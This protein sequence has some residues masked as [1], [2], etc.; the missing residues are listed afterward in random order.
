MSTQSNDH[1]ITVKPLE[2]RGQRHIG[3]FFEYNSA[4][5]EQIKS[6]PQRKYSV[7]HRCWYIPYDKLSWHLFLQL[8]LPIDIVDAHGTRQTEATSDNAIIYPDESI[9][10]DSPL[11][12][13]EKVSGNHTSDI[14]SSNEDLTSIICQGGQFLITIKYNRDEIN[15]L[16]KLTASYWHAG[17]SKWVCKST[18]GNHKKLQERYKYWSKLQ[19]TQLEKVLKV[20][21]KS[22][23]ARIDVYDSDKS[24]YSIRIKNADKA[25]SLIK[26]KS[27]R[28]YKTDDG[29]WIISSA[30]CDIDKLIK[31]L[32]DMNVHVQDYRLL[33]KHADVAYSRDWSVRSKY[34][35]DKVPIQQKEVLTVYVHQ[36]IQERKSWNTIKQYFGSFLK[37]VLHHDPRSV[38]DLGQDDI[39]AYIS[40]IA[41]GV[42]SH[43][44]INR[45]QSA[46]RFY[47]NR[48]SDL[49]I[50]FDKIPRPKVAKSLPKILSKGEV[51]LM[52][53]SLTNVKHLAMLY[54][55]YGAGLRSGEITTLQLRDI[56][57]ERN[58][59]WV[60]RGK[61][62]KDRVVTMAKSIKGILRVYLSKYKLQ[63]S[64][65]FEG[66]KPGK[67]YSSSSLSQ[68]FKRALHLSGIPTNYVLHSL[69][70]S[71]ATHLL[72]AGTDVRLIKELLGHKD[73]KT[74]LIYTHI[75]DQTLNSI[76]SP[77]DTLE[78]NK[79]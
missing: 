58:Q 42:A 16:K 63:G 46:I 64:Y 34:L 60:R 21:Y 8:G 37:F 68:I 74:T 55:A 38:T 31:E 7:T 51:S 77:L 43:S 35:L 52:L 49:D 66:S 5:I 76:V 47:Y 40:H 15:F 59:I 70:H 67:P 73:I 23:M 18:I 2:H 6:I 12:E 33:V 75:S 17:E 25:I 27:S 26:S 45:H 29:Q 61:G 4:F 50:S 72:D 78:L 54:L 62:N 11:S 1:T 9:S 14:R 30:T 39:R 24:L 13:C 44:E 41:N 71:Y 69:R 20:Q 56:D 48:L 79:T 28:D 19:Y 36:L 53:S 32:S 22:A 3:L 10:K 65:L 57:W